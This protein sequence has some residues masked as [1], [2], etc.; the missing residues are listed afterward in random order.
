MEKMEKMEKKKE[1]AS[2]FKKI[3][4]PFINQQCND[5]NCLL[6]HLE[7]ICYHFYVKGRC[8]Y[9][10]Q[11]KYSHQYKNN[12][13]KK[14]KNKHTNRSKKNTESFTP[15][16]KPCDLRIKFSDA[17]TYS[18]YYPYS[19]Q[20]NDAIVVHNLFQDLNSSPKNIY[21]TLLDE[22][23]T[24]DKNDQIWKLWHG[25]TH[26]IADDHIKGWKE[27]CPMLNEILHR[28]KVFFN[29]D[30]KATR[31]N[32]FRDDQDWKP[33]HHDAA[34]IDKEKAKTQNITMGVSFGNTREASFEHATTRTTV[35]IPLEDGTVYGF[36]SKVNMDWRHGIPQI[37][38]IK[39]DQEDNGRISI[40]VWGWVNE[41]K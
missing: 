32:Y 18:G 22:I 29:I 35:N 23:K 41:E 5:T 15:S 17:S 26:L 11:C 13:N 39:N 2:V 7:N 40:I 10:D 6:P 38:Q 20:S 36:C 28:L 27:K 8:K 1:N 16:H 33:Y 3:C 9:N 19:F 31:F 24:V 30:V 34:A 14:E 37:P 4:I 21:H 25:D 12:E